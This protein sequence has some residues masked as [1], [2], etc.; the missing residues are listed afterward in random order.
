MVS[1][2]LLLNLLII[3]V[4][5][6]P[7]DCVGYIGKK[8]EWTQVNNTNKNFPTLKAGYMIIEP[9]KNNDELYWGDIKI[10]NYGGT[11]E[12]TGNYTLSEVDNNEECYLQ[13]ELPIPA[14]KKECITFS[15]T[16]DHKS[17]V[18]CYTTNGICLP[19]C[20]NVFAVS[21]IAAVQMQP[22]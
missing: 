21:W 4:Y 8:L 9:G 15:P 20:T 7:K 3:S 18:G 17:F 6:Q 1:V 12:E 2:F 10:L 11:A 16:L 13:L 19:T 14:E 22:K 5:S